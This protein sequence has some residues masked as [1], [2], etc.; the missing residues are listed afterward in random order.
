ML[1]IGAQHLPTTDSEDV[2]EKLEN[3]SSRSFNSIAQMMDQSDMMSIM[4]VFSE[5]IL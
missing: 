4:E 2:Y 3:E 1:L 5:K